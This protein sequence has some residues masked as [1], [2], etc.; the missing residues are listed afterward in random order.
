MTGS[1]RT[2]LNHDW[3][4][5]SFYSQIL[6]T[7]SNIGTL[8]GIRTG[9]TQLTLQTA[10]LLATRDAISQRWLR[11]R[12]QV[13]GGTYPS[14][15]MQLRSR[16]DVEDF[17]VEYDLTRASPIAEIQPNTK[18]SSLKD[19]FRLISRSAYEAMIDRLARIHNYTHLLDKYPATVVPESV[20]TTAKSGTS[21]PSVV[22]TAKISAGIP[23]TPPPTEAT[24]SSTKPL[25]LI[26]PAE[27]TVTLTFQESRPVERPI[28]ATESPAA[29]V[30]PDVP[31]E[32]TSLQDV[33]SQYHQDQRSLEKQLYACR[34][35]IPVGSHVFESFFH[36]DVS[37]GLGRKKAAPIACRNYPRVF[38]IVRRIPGYTID[39]E[40]VE[41]L[42]SNIT[43]REEAQKFY[44]RMP[45]DDPRRVEDDGH[46]NMIDVLKAGRAILLGKP[47]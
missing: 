43:K 7:L 14:P 46:Q 26:T 3:D 9:K 27:S 19:A 18:T 47:I 28:N 30:A 31:T 5:L 10:V 11:T 35:S 23:S 6:P 4:N 17:L 15:L 12:E 44:Q 22:D 13:D 32:G 8:L 33:V 21:K 34:T 36:W 24:G 20:A 38:G 39:P 45:I 40:M 16:G 2:L 41:T 37:D 25:E 29:K 42:E 1:Y